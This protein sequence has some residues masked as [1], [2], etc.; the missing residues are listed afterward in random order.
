MQQVPKALALLCKRFTKNPSWWGLFVLAFAQRDQVEEVYR[1]YQFM[2]SPSEVLEFLVAGVESG[3]PAQG[4]RDYLRTKWRG[5]SKQFDREA[6]VVSLTEA[7]DLD[8][9]LHRKALLLKLTD[10]QLQ[11]LNLYYIEELTQDQIAE[12]LG[13]TRQTIINRIKKIQALLDR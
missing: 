1:L 8:E 5:I 7:P 4:C 6:F 11:F 13:V 2:A 12:L 9:W 10:E 3:N